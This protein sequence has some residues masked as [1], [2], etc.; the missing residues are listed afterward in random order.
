MKSQP[1]PRKEGYRGVAAGAGVRTVSTAE[2]ASTI[3]RQRLMS[4]AVL[5]LCY[6]H[7]KTRPYMGGGGASAVARAAA[8]AAGPR[9]GR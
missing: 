9:L 4:S 7:R 6:A 8:V 2:P 5:W 1:A 3:I